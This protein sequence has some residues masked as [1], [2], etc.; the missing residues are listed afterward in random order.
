MITGEREA[1]IHTQK[2]LEGLGTIQRIWDHFF[3][4]PEPPFT[5][6]LFRMALALLVITDLLLRRPDWLTWYGERGIVTRDTLSVAHLGSRLNIFRL[7]P[8]SD[9]A[10]NVCWWAFLVA[11]IF[12]L[13]GLFTRVSSIGVFL[14][15]LSTAQRNPYILN[16]GDTVLRLCSLFLIFAPA[17]RAL[18]VDRLTRVYQGR[19]GPHVGNYAPWARRLIQIQISV[20]Y[21]STFCWKLT[22]ETW[23]NGTAVYYALHLIEFQRYPIPFR[24]SFLFSRIATWGTLL[25]EFSLGSFIWIEEYRNGCCSL[26]LPCILP[27]ITP[28]RFNCLS[29]L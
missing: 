25:V 20:L 16:G 23:R 22:G 14:A 12:L 15:L 28:W 6:A 18:S 17:G 21:L 4:D 3:F 27:S 19:E 2:R 1:Q 5:V 26:A 24:D 29:G 10:M 13:V 8:S 9:T 7:V 11:A